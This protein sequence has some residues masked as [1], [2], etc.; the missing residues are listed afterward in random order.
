MLKKILNIL[1]N[2]DNYSIAVF[3]SDRVRLLIMPSPKPVC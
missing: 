3:M 2:F 1:I